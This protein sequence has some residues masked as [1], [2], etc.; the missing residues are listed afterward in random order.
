[1]KLLNNIYLPL[2]IPATWGTVFSAYPNLWIVHCTGRVHSNVNPVSQLHWWVPFR[3]G[4]SEDATKHIILDPRKDPLKNVYDALG[5]R[6]KEK[7]LKVALN[8]INEKLH[9]SVDYSKLVT[10]TLELQLSDQSSHYH[11]SATYLTVISISTEEL[12]NWKVAYQQDSHLSPVLKAE[13]GEHI[14]K[15]LNIKLSW[16]C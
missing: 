12:E 10:D 15:I 11:T 9:N 14:D 13:E 6:F 16:V 7:L 5:G 4:P 2:L 3:S 8:S 1:M